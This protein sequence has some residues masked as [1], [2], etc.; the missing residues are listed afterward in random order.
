MRAFGVSGE[1]DNGRRVVEFF[2]ER[3]LYVGSTYFEH[4]SLPKYTRELGA[5]MEWR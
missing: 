5:K 2:A 4:K 3:L 1:N